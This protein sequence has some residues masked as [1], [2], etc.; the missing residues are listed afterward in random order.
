MQMCEFMYVKSK[1]DAIRNSKGKPDAIQNSKGKSDEKRIRNDS[2]NNEDAIKLQVTEFV[3]D[4]STT[5]SPATVV[6]V[7][8]ILKGFFDYE[9][10]LGQMQTNPLSD[11]EPPKLEKKSKREFAFSQIPQG[12]S[13]KAVRDRAMITVL[14]ETGMKV[15]ELL[16]LKLQNVKFDKAGQTVIVLE[17]S[18]IAQIGKDADRQKGT[19]TKTD[20]SVRY[21]GKEASDILYDYIYATREEILAG[22]TGNAKTENVATDLLFTNMDGRAMSRQGFWKNMRAYGREEVQAQI[23]HKGA[24]GKQREET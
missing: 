7:I 24:Q 18:D 3:S 6:Q 11:I 2:A 8:S 23:T 14:G 5:K 10:S 19:V 1:S 9:I 13:A 16:Q 15:S 22:A 4:L 21:L 12:Y 20:S 17:K